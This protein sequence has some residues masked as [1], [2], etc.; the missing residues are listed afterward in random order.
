MGNQK[1]GT[2]E[3]ISLILIVIISHLLLN[4]PQ[5]II[6]TCGTSSSLNIIYLSIISILI[7]CLIVWL[8]KKFP[9]SD[10]IDISD[11]LGGRILKTIVGIIIIAYALFFAEILLRNAVEALKIIYYFNSRVTFV[12]IFFILTPIIANIFG[13]RA[14][15]KC[16]LIITPL[17]IVV[18]L[19]AFISVSPL[20]VWQR[21]FPIFGYGINNTFGIDGLSN[22]FAYNG[23]LVVMLLL[24]LL[25]TPKNFKKI[26]ITAIFISCILLF[27]FVTTLLL[28]FPYVLSVESI[29]PIYLMVVNT[30]F[31]TFF[32]RPEALFIFVWILFFMSY[33]NVIIMFCLRIFKKVTKIENTKAMSYSF[34]TLLFIFTFIPI[35]MTEVRF[36]ENTVYKYSTIILTFFISFAILIGANIKYKILNKKSS[37]KGDANYNV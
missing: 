20:F 7:C 19:I 16:N 13:E 8:M 10:V 27:L 18:L 17:I 2:L 29:A 11:Y 24:P 28:A 32:Q 33:L 21:I 37:K 35:G 1:I 9:N 12:A 6:N 26:S 34:S 30:Q 15:I 25:S 5:T 31:S 23:L 22:I 3:G 4:I 14:I 36:L